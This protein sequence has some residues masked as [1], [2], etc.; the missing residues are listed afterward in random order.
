LS[1]IPRGESIRRRRTRSRSRSPHSSSRSPRGDRTNKTYDKTYERDNRSDSHRSSKTD[2]KKK[3]PRK[4]GKLDKKD[5]GDK[6][7]PVVKKERLSPKKDVKKN[8]DV[9]KVEKKKDYVVPKKEEELEDL[10]KMDVDLRKLKLEA[11]DTSEEVSMD[12]DLRQKVT[13]DVVVEP[14]QQNVPV[15]VVEP[16]P[17]EDVD[18]RLP[19]VNKEQAVSG[20]E[21]RDERAFAN[22]GNA[23]EMSNNGAIASD[24][25]ERKN[26][27]ELPTSDVDHRMPQLEQLEPAEALPMD[28]AAVDTLPKKDLDLRSPPWQNE[29]QAD[30]DEF[31]SRASTPLMDEP[32]EPP[33]KKLKKD[34]DDRKPS[35]SKEDN[36]DLR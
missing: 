32:S 33:A 36:S 11:V 17:M 1:P 30:D 34:L 23:D 19:V 16:V 22:I 4:D 10:P 6:A 21:D 14:V 12:I 35:E 3:S 9:P 7:K 28:T 29:S 2:E 25:D 31:D 13:V 15:D 5:V 24:F 18:E 27:L 20:M 26:D 8:A